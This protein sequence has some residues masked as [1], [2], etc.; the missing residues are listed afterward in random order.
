MNKKFISSSVQFFLNG[1]SMAMMFYICFGQLNQLINISHVAEYIMKFD[2]NSFLI[3]LIIAF[4]LQFFLGRLCG[5]KNNFEEIIKDFVTSSKICLP[6]LLFLPSILSF[7]RSS[8]EEFTATVIGKFINFLL[9]NFI[10]VIYLNYITPALMVIVISFIGIRFFAVLAERKSKLLEFEYKT[11]HKMQLLMLLLI[12]TVI[13]IGYGVYLQ[14]SY[15]NKLLLLYY[16]WGIF[17]N[18]AENSL[19]GNW[20]FSNEVQHNFMGRHMM[21]LSII[22]IMPFVALSKSIDTMFYL[23]SIVLFGSSFV[24]FYLARAYKLRLGASFLVALAYLLYPSITNLNLALY[25]GF[26]CIYFIIPIVWLFFILLQ[27]EH[28]KWA[29]VVFFLSMLIKE[30]VPVLWFG[31]GVYMLFTKRYKWALLMFIF[32]PIYFVI[33]A[34]YMM[35]HF[36]P[37]GFEGDEKYYF[38]SYYKI[39]A[40]NESYKEII[41]APFTNPKTFFGLLF[42][43]TSIHFIILL[44][45][46]FMPFVIRYPLP[47]LG[48]VAWYGLLL[49]QDSYF[50]HN[51]DMQYQ[52]EIIP[53]VFLAVII[54]CKYFN[55]S[56]WGKIWS[57]ICFYNLDLKKKFQRPA[58]LLFGVIPA[59]LCSAYFYG[60]YPY[61]ANTTVQ[62]EYARDHRQLVAKVKEILPKKVSA[63]I[64]P[65]LAGHF[66]LRNDVWL[67]YNK[68]KDYVVIGYDTLHSYLEH[69]KFTTLHEIILSSGKYQLL[70]RPLSD[71]GNTVLIYKRGAPEN[72]VHKN[73]Q[74]QNMSN[75]QFA[76]FGALYPLRG[77]DKIE[78]R[79]RQARTNTEINFLIG[80]QVKKK[81]HDNYYFD[82]QLFDKKTKNKFYDETVYFGHGFTPP[83]RAKINDVFVFLVKAPVPSGIGAN[84]IIFANQVGTQSGPVQERV[85][86]YLPM[87]K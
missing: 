83:W 45:M 65:Q 19:K 6:S 85:Q 66:V 68:P 86:K 61:A 14:R 31:V 2:T 74:L 5:G 25:Y 11:E 3:S 38:F 87:I 60:E 71:G 75:K 16:D 30:S 28:Y 48:G 17:L 29:L 57:K 81:L 26:H 37:T 13:F 8:D 59:V 67:N 44:T 34:K 43:P 84:D 20:F 55:V 49:I 77:D 39:L 56:K 18:T 4:A 21:P 78:I 35:P 72:K 69:E 63:T 70:D 32:C 82:I 40:P 22:L 47:L 42:R 79:I 15:F 51:L 50:R 76:K 7:M 62:F 80:V 9:I 46:S 36:V 54:G 52:T 27:K 10:D 64:T 1:I 58:I 53:F 41:F 33:V 12:F 73:L 23:N 24:V